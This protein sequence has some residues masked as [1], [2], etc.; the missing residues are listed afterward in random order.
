MAPG[1]SKSDRETVPQTLSSGA[2][3]GR[4]DHG[5]IHCYGPEVPISLIIGISIFTLPLVQGSYAAE[6]SRGLTEP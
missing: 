4:K 3:E 1:P 6:G 5:V 2:A